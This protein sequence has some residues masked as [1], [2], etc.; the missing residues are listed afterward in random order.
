M[1]KQT[2]YNMCLLISIV[3]DR[4]RKCVIR[5]SYLIGLTLF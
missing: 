1:S 3:M 5:A 2:L 4:E